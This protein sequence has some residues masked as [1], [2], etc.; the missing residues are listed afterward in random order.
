MKKSLFLV[1]ELLIFSLS[2]FAQYYEL[3]FSPITDENKQLLGGAFAIA[4]DKQGFI[5]FGMSNGLLR[6]DGYTIKQF[7]NKKNDHNSLSNN[8]VRSLHIDNEGLIWIGT[9]GGGLNC[10]NTE[11]EIFKRFV[12]DPNDKKSISNNDIWAIKED[13]QGNLWLG[14]WDGGLNKFNKQ[15]GECVRYQH[16]NDENSISDNIVRSICEDNDGNLWIGT[17]SGGLNK[18]ISHSQKFIRYKNNPRIAGTL[19][20][21]A[22]YCVYKDGENK[23]WA[24]TFGGG[25]NQYD[26]RTD[27][28]IVYRNQPTDQNSL[29][30]NTTYQ[31]IKSSRNKFWIAME[32]EGLCMYN[33]I[34]K[35]FQLYRHDRRNPNSI[36]S[37]RVRFLFEDSN[38][39][40][41]VGTE[42]G[43]DKMVENK[44]FLT[45]RHDP[46]NQ[47]TISDP[48]VRSIYE[49]KHGLLWICSFSSPVV[50]Y[51]KR[52]NRFNKTGTIQTT[53]GLK[54]V[55]AM[56]EDDADNFWFGTRNGLYVFDSNKILKKRYLHSD[57]CKNCVSDNFIQIIR[58]GNN[59]EIWIGTENGL[60][61]FDPKTETWTNYLINP[62]DTTSISSNKIQPCAL[63]IEKDNT[64]WAGTWS[65]GLNKYIPEKNIIKRFINNPESNNTISSNNV[66]SMYQTADGLLWLGTFGG[67]L[68]RFDPKTETFKA[69]TETE[70]LPNN[71]VFGILGDRNGKLWLST[72]NGLSN[73]D[74]KT[75]TFHNF[76]VKDGIQGRQFFWGAAFMSNSGEMFFGGVDG[77][78][79]FFPEKI[80]LNNHIPSIKFVDV[81]RANQSLKFNKSI[82][83]IQELEFAYNETNLQIEF[84]ALDY[85]EPLKNQFAYKLFGK[86]EDWIMNGN[87]NF[88]NFSDIQPGSYKLMVKASNNDG[89]W[90]TQPAIIQLVVLPPWWATWWFRMFGI[91]CFGGVYV[92]FYLYRVA[93]LK[94]RQK[95]LEDKV[96][97]RT[98]ELETANS[99]LKIKQEEIINQNDA[100]LELAEELSM[101]KDV[102]SEQNHKLNEQH[103]N[104]KASLRYALTIQQAFL[105]PENLL[106][107]IFN[108]FILY[109]P[110]DI[111]SGDFYW[112]TTI[113]N[114]EELRVKSEEFEKSEERK[115]K[116]EESKNTDVKHSSLFT[117]HSSLTH[118]SLIHFI[119]VVDCTGHGVPGA[120]MSMIGTR[121]LN[122]IVIEKKIYDP[123]VVLNHLD[124]GIISSLRQNTTENNDGMDITLCQIQ[125][126]GDACFKVV[127]AGAKS[128]LY[129][130][131]KS[132]QEIH[133][134]KGSH[135]YIG[136]VDVGTA[137]EKFETTTLHLAT[138]DVLY[139]STDGYIDQN[140]KDRKRFGRRRLLEK[141]RN[142]AELDINQQYTILETELRNWQN[143][144]EQRDDI[145]VL[146]IKL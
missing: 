4:E 79:S 132:S 98:T 101:Q 144:E 35:T 100:I 122:E 87:R 131:K 47:N 15:T 55:T 12:N 105:P 81:K 62:Q 113:N 88:V 65:G 7:K 70:G 18:F 22:V 30:K 117:L 50:S 93:Q 3:K 110:K 99:I 24:C 145:T 134:V 23:I 78:N 42:A 109:K 39:I 58:K 77:M 96:K 67:G 48:I 53:A 16:S 19:S 5:W 130:Y 129:Y 57:N 126:T 140:N 146:G 120:F 1:V 95:E 17:H 138:D 139:L 44:N 114:S 143:N 123:G 135:Q 54:S 102:L 14:T 10:F 115:V 124:E 36:S 25:I 111:V 34:S 127:F 51:D 76:D 45:F 83:Y 97:E 89:L 11:T 141:L 104:I 72:D 29:P 92:A 9:Q 66:I 108:C 128:N 63:I 91:I 107:D 40:I 136:R 46:D 121:L 82:T 137:K 37:D 64:V 71:I 119:A 68:N 43:V 20:N 69:Y 60:N 61:R 90:N 133:I 32:N 56:F 125:K 94:K 21:D 28:F 41:W 116:S 26:S 33:P 74:P 86:S 49:D 38:G 13:K 6:Y 142:L 73:F 80:K 59:G 27:K 84:A 118:S 106:H 52:T 31:I 103:E 2:G 85:T 112:Y 8:T 75:E